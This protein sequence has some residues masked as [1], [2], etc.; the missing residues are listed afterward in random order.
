MINFFEIYMNSIL[1]Y[2]DI[3]VNDDINSKELYVCNLLTS[4]T[5]SSMKQKLEDANKKGR[6]GW[7]SDECKISNLYKLRDKALSD[8]DHI[9]VI[10]YTAMIA[11]R[12]SVK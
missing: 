6:G 7:W 5:V 8:N 2:D 9:S 1:S 3:I 10:N 11:M 4:A 12:E